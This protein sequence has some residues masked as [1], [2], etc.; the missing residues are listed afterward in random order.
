MTNDPIEVYLDKLRHRRWMLRPD[1]RLIAEVEDHLRSAARALESDR[2]LA[3]DA[4]MREAV[5]RFGNPGHLRPR[6]LDPRLL[7]L[8]VALTVATITVIAGVL[9]WD[10]RSTVPACPPHTFCVVTQPSGEQLHPLR[11]EMLWATS[12]LVSAVVGLRHVRGRGTTY[13]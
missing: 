10:M 9:A 6:L 11:A 7:M 2:G 3:P 12:A 8:A 4:A 1:G 5:A 13:S